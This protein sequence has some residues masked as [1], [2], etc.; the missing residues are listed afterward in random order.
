MRTLPTSQTF[1]R[2]T[3]SFARDLALAPHG[4][5][6]LRKAH[7]MRFRDLF[8]EMVTSNEAN[9]YWNTNTATT[10]WE[11]QRIAAIRGAYETLKCKFTSAG[12]AKILGREVLS[13]IAPFLPP[14]EVVL[15]DPEPTTTQANANASASSSASPAVPQASTPEPQLPVLQSESATPREQRFASTG[16]AASPAAA[17]APPS[18]GVSGN[19]IIDNININT[20][21]DGDGESPAYVPPALASGHDSG[22]DD[23]SDDEAG[24]GGGGGSPAPQGANASADSSDD[25]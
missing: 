16:S 4:I 10:A 20:D 6:N 17:A 1:L 24:R 11:A 8:E 25:E 2:L 19:N 22:D 18:T 9:W 7:R 12:A 14:G 23:S 3:I 21:D 15:D 5:S 13:R